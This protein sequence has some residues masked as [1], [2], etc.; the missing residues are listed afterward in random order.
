MTLESFYQLHPRVTRSFKK[1]VGDYQQQLDEDTFIQFLEML[2]ESLL[3]QAEDFKAQN[4]EELK[5]RHL[6]KITD[7]E[8]A[9]AEIPSSCFKGCSACCHMEVEITNY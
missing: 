8:I 5:A 2:H 6:H 1:Y 3:E 7:A 9:K 4:T